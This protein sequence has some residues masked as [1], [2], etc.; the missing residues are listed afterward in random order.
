MNSLINDCEKASSLNLM[1][2]ASNNWHQW[3]DI[4]QVIWCILMVLC[5]YTIKIVTGIRKESSASRSPLSNIM[6][7]FPISLKNLSRT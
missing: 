3:L 1:V 5:F 2:N 4:S 7:I 6:S